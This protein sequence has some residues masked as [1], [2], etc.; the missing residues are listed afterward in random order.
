MYENI[1]CIFMLIN[2]FVLNSTLF[3]FI[4]IKLVYKNCNVVKGGFQGLKSCKMHLTNVLNNRII[5]LDHYYN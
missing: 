3:Q 2:F 1:Q 5:E 4:S